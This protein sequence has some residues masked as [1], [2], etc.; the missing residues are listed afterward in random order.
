MH[1]PKHT[2]QN[3]IRRQPLPAIPRHRIHHIAH[4]ARFRQLIIQFP[5]CLRGAPLVTDLEELDADLPRG[6]VEFVQFLRRGNDGGLDVVGG[7]AVRDDDDVDGF[8]VFVPLLLAFAEVGAEEGVEAAAGRGA[9][10]GADGVEN[11][12]DGL[13]GGDVFVLGRVA[14]VEEVDVDAVGVVGGA[15]AGDGGEGLGGFAPGASGHGAGIVNDEFG[16]EFGEE[17]ELV[18]WVGGHVA[19]DD[20]AV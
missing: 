16:V 8:A 13:L 3:L 19:G 4:I 5:Q 2:L 18:V 14:L 17:G 9:A 6:R 7:H 1:R 10:A 15:D 12:L 11:L 20:G